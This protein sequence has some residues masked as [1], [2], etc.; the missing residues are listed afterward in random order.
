MLDKTFATSEVKMV[1]DDDWLTPSE[2][3]VPPQPPPSAAMDATDRGRLQVCRQQ[4]RTN[5]DGSDYHFDIL[6]GFFFFTYL[7]S[8]LHRSF[9]PCV[10]VQ[11]TAD[12]D[13]R[14][15]M[16]GLISTGVFDNKTW[17][18]IEAEVRLEL[19]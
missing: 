7:S 14:I 15:V 18:L 16:D 19:S 9:E 13:V 12:L 3:T 17:Q 10:P 6:F 5:V 2:C 8:T 4:E 1:P 11:V